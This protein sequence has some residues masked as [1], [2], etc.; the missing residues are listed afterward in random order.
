M[1]S[2]RAFSHWVDHKALA[3]ALHVP[4]QQKCLSHISVGSFGSDVRQPAYDFLLS[5]RVSVHNACRLVCIFAYKDDYA[6]MLGPRVHPRGIDHRSDVHSGEQRISWRQMTVTQ[7]SALVL[8]GKGGGMTR[9]IVDMGPGCFVST[10]GQL[11]P[12]CL[13]FMSVS[14]MLSLKGNIL[15]GY[16]SDLPG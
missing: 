12:G 6:I 8:R 10:C 13:V 5:S 4:V 16:P 7:E 3:A 9:V 15:R 14:S 1:W 2:L 11:S